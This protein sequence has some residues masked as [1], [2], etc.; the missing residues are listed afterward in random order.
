[1]GHA[2][3]LDGRTACFGDMYESQVTYHLYFWAKKKTKEQRC[4][5]PFF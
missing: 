4:G 2:P 3:L 5:Y 1:V